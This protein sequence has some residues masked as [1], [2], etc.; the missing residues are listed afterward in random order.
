MHKLNSKAPPEFSSF[1]I[2]VFESI[3][4]VKR[5]GRRLS[6]WVGLMELYG[7]KLKLL[8]ISLT[9]SNSEGKKRKCI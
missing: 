9:E 1:W 8:L 7:T 5:T 2:K 6:Q 4:G 3:V